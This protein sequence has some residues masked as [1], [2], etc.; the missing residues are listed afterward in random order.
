MIERI[1]KVAFKII[2]GERYT[3][4]EFSCQN[5]NTTTLENRREK[6]CKSFITKNLKSKNSFFSLVQKNVNTRINML[7][8]S[9]NS[10]AEQKDI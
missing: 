7:T 5:F 6:I 1:R 8:K 4:Y 3:S 9:E 10:S 2:L